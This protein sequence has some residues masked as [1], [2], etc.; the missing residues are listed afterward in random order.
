MQGRR[1]GAGAPGLAQDLRAKRH[2]ARLPHL[3]LRLRMLRLQKRPPLRL[4]V[5]I[6]G[7]P[8]VQDQSTLGLLLVLSAK[9][10]KQN[11]IVTPFLFDCCFS[12]A[13]L[14]SSDVWFQPQKCISTVS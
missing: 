14:F 7:K 9:N 3:H 12:L 5:P 2:R 8:H 13:F 10:K 1:D 11:K 4:R 6:R